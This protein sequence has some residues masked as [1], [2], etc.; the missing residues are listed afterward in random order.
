MA[1]LTGTQKDQRDGS[2]VNVVIITGSICKG[3]T[4][5]LYLFQRTQRILVVQRWILIAYK[6]LR[7][8]LMRWA[9]LFKNLWRD[10]WRG[11]IPQRVN[12][13][14][15]KAVTRRARCMR[16]I[17]RLEPKCLRIIGMLVHIVHVVHSCCSCCWSILFMLWNR[18]EDYLNQRSDMRWV[19]V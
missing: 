17:N 12:L 18:V 13:G 15:L 2:F 8:K 10:R 5:S 19:T 4:G 14:C 6:P 11:L 9:E 3:L 16:T 1:K 7:R